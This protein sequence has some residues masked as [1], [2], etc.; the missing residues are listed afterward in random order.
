MK[1]AFFDIHLKSIQL[2]TSPKLKT[3][4]KMLDLAIQS[5]AGFIEQLY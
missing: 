3:L 4:M 1:S 5:V 2:T